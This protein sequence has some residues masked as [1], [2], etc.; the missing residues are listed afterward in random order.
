MLSSV[1]RRFPPIAKLLALRHLIRASGFV[2]PGHFYSPVVSIDEIR[3]DEQRVF[4]KPHASPGGIDMNEAGQ[5]ELLAHFES[6]Y[7]SI[8]F[9]VR[10]SASH[11]YHYE[12]PAYGHSDAIIL[13]CMMR[14]FK[15]SRIIEVGSGYSSCAILD[16]RERHLGAKVEVTFIEPFPELLLSLVRPADRNTF[17]VLPTRLQ[18][19]PIETFRSLQSGDLLFIDST[20]VSKT[21]SDV[22]Y[23]FFEVLPALNAGVHVHLH[24]IF[25][26]F[27]YP[28]EWVMGGRSWN[29]IYVLRAFLQFNTAFSI[30]MMNTYLQHFHRERFALRMPLCLKNS[31]GSIWM[32]R[33]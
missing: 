26:P 11:R 17:E 8:D 29:E 27:E 28:K 20:H 3:R 2:P 24:D 33:K 23:L 16:T 15:P 13:A 22:N 32:L 31:G 6:I 21:G 5:L 10:K 9:P 1:L 18:D 4:H 25:Y 14:H 12:N 30:S 7:P 19:V